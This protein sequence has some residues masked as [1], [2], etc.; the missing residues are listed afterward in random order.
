M[1]ALV[2]FDG[3][4]SPKEDYAIGDLVTLSNDDDTGVTTWA[5]T[6][7]S[8]PEGSAAAL[9]SGSAASPTFTADKEGSY[10]VKLTTNSGLG[11]EAQANGVARIV[12]LHKL[13]KPPAKGETLEAGALGWQGPRLHNDLII[14]KAISLAD[15]RTV[16]YTGA[17]TTG[18]KVLQLTGVATLA[19]GD[20]VPTAILATISASPGAVAGKA[21]VFWDG[22][23][24]NT[25]DVVSALSKGLSLS[26]ADGGGSWSA[27]PTAPVFLD[28]TG[29]NIVD[30][31]AGPNFMQVWTLGVAITHGAGLI[32]IWFDPWVTDSYGNHWNNDGGAGAFQHPLAEDLSVTQAGFMRFEESSKLGNLLLV[33]QKIVNGNFNFWQRGTDDVTFTDNIVDPDKLGVRQIIADRWWGIVENNTGGGDVTADV[34]YS[35]EPHSDGDGGYYIQ[36]TNNDAAIVAGTKFCIVQEIDREMLVRMRGHYVGASVQI[37]AG[38]SFPSDA[39]VQIKL[40]V[41]PSGSF[42]PD[43]NY[44]QYFDQPG[45]DYILQST[46]VIP[47]PGGTLVTSTTGG[48]TIPTDCVA[49]AL[50]IS[51]EY[52]S[53]GSAGD[54]DDYLRF[55]SAQM[56]DSPTG[57]DA[58]SLDL[59]NN[60]FQHAGGSYDADLLLCQ[61]FFQKSYRIR[62]PPGGAA[63]FDGVREI[64][65]A[66]DGVKCVPSVNLDRHMWAAPTVTLYDVSGV[67]GQVSLDTDGD[68]GALETNVS[69]AGFRVDLGAGE[70]A[71]QGGRFHWTADCEI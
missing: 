30:Y 13:L 65:V 44:T 36:V 19:N 50:V 57:I 25:N 10:L 53:A 9:S 11:D 68:V 27:V 43:D 62:N 21:L 55:R 17:N 33:E 60:A 34:T 18:P 70:T 42:A 31:P 12:T 64:I 61:K 7:Y 16:K 26:V 71:G 37:E 20:I 63:D 49:A 39:E 8:K 40:L 2:L 28:D 15:R 5:W 54:A 48:I 29:G 59:A 22:G 41:A 46:P 56:W 14:D 1:A 58:S 51:V 38:S 23:A 45:T 6:L 3:D 4:P 32:R 66:G 69:Q 24:L 47:G 52:T 67:T 35:Q